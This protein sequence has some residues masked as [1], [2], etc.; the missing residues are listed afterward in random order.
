MGD[1]ME[2]WEEQ[3]LAENE[4]NFS[5]SLQFYE[6]IQSDGKSKNSKSGL[7]AKVMSLKQETKGKG[8]MV[9]KML[10]EEWKSSKSSLDKQL[11]ASSES[12]QSIKDESE[13]EE[14][15]LQ[16]IK[17]GFGKK[18]K[19]IK[20]DI[21]DIKDE[22]LHSFNELKETYQEKAD[23]KKAMITSFTEE[24]KRIFRKGS[25]LPPQVCKQMSTAYLTRR[26]SVIRF[27]ILGARNLDT[28]LVRPQD[29]I[30]VKVSLGYEKFKTQSVPACE[31]PVWMETSSLPGQS[32]EDEEIIVELILRSSKETKT[33]FSGSLDLNSYPGDT[34]SRV[35]LVLGGES[36]ECEMDMVVWVTSVRLQ[37]DTHDLQGEDTK[38]VEGSYALAKTLDN[39]SDV[40]V[41]TIQVIDATGLGSN[42]LQGSVNPFCQLQLGNQFHRTATVIKTKN[43]TWNK[44]FQFHVT[45]PFSSLHISVI[46]ERI[47]S[48]QVVLGQAVIRLSTLHGKH[49]CQKITVSLKD[50]KLRKPAKGDNPVLHLEVRYVHNPMR[51]GITV[52]GNKEDALCE[53]PKAKFEHT[54]LLRNVS[55]LKYFLPKGSTISC[56]KTCYADI[57]AWKD[58]YTTIKY[59][60]LYTLFVYNFQIWFIPVFLLYRLSLNWKNKKR[61]DNRTIPRI[62]VNDDDI[63]EEDDEEEESPEEKKSLKQSID[64][65]QNIL[66]EFQEGSGLVASYFER[67]SNLSDFEEPFLTCVFCVLLVLCSLVLGACGLRTVLLLWGLNKITKKLRDPNPVPTNELDNLILSVPDF[68][69]VEDAKPLHPLAIR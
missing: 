5:D 20:E 49:G 50:R 48:P 29:N 13:K 10:K 42:K 31:Q 11:S 51:A 47:N 25:P 67:I 60:I 12:L 39:I 4:E 33:L 63:E 9:I 58:P 44:Y 57:I 8:G 23:Q 55:R 1:N 19:D 68:E 16:K 52:L 56:L 22:S 64:S 53:V 66:L 21:I 15:K 17:S 2:E 43:P 26:F 69:M 35:K 62:S 7:T 59:F 14:S 18:I 32:E 30:L 40:G 28:D 46:S 34:Q 41:L 36:G 65:L 38:K 45:G 54:T 27:T 61:G 24:E 6:N 3:V 37:D